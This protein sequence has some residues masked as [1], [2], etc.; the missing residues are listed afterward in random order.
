MILDGKAI[1][2]DKNFEKKIGKEK[3]SVFLLW[4]IS[5]KD[6]HGYEIIK[7]IK[8]EPHI[9]SFAASKIYPLLKELNKKG[10]IT[11]K[12]VMQGKRAR[13][14]YSITAK[15]KE[16]LQKIREFLRNSPLLKQYAE[17]MLI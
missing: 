12:R 9:P 17:D 3:F 2:H 6:M 8:E 11:Q 15:G 7:T 14:V 5:K 1:A 10:L 4:L 13:K 16:A